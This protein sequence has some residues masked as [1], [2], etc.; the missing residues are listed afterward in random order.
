VRTVFKTLDREHFFYS[1]SHRIFAQNGMIRSSHLQE[2]PSIRE[3]T[4]REFHLSNLT[5]RR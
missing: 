4:A 1:W 2:L 5:Y 3:L